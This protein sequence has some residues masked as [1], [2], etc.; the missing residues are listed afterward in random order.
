MMNY[1]CKFVHK[2]RSQH[3]VEGTIH[4]RRK[5]IAVQQSML[6]NVYGIAVV[7]RFHR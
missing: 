1:Y 7:E 2:S 4:T 5:P 3:F 6:N